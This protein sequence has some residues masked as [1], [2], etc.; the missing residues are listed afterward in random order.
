MFHSITFSTNNGVL[1]GRKGIHPD[2]SDLA[3]AD[4]SDPP[5]SW[6]I[7][8]NGFKLGELVIISSAVQMK[9]AELAF[10]LHA[11]GV[12]GKDVRLLAGIFDGIAA[13]RR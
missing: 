5:L 3:L 11:I 6:T 4:M 1:Y 7:P 12:P 13:R 10:M 9:L 8:A 2:G